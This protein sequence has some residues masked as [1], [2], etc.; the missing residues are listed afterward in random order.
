M[1]PIESPAFAVFIFFFGLSLGSFLNVVIY[2]LPK[3]ESIVFPASHCASCLAPIRYRDNIPLL[4]YLLLGGRCRNCHERISPLYPAVELTTGGL[5]LVFF[6]LHGLSLRFITDIA[7]AAILIA[8]FCIDL[9]HG[10]IPNRLTM[11]GGIIGGILAVLHGSSG[12]LRAFT[13]ALAGILILGGM[14]L[15]GTLIFRRESLGMGDIKLG[16]VTGIFLGPFGNV[17]A[18]ASAV[19]L[20]GLWGTVAL[21]CRKSRP[22]AEIPFGPFIAAGCIIV[23]FWND[24]LLRLIA[25]YLFPH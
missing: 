21:S 7:L 24:A 9:R 16:A 17:L 10:I 18:I 2:R 1:I 5:F 8:V 25:T 22:G 19:I 20:G 11:S 4:G 13:G 23:L 15:L 3:K 12:I 14:A 6:L